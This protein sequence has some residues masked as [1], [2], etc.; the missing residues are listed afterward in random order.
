[1][2]LIDSP[3]RMRFEHVLHHAS[4][5]HPQMRQELETAYAVMWPKVPFSEGAWAN[6]PGQNMDLLSQAQ[7]RIYL[8]SAAISGDPAWQEG[9]VESAWR[10]V[11]TLHERVVNQ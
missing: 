3:I 5:V 10:T 8:G 7:G 2:R 6:G 11:E 9:A 4:K 1:M